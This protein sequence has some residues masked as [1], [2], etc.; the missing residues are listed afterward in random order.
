MVM[1]IV[2]GGKPKAARAAV[3]LLTGALVLA[4]VPA[5]GDVWILDRTASEIRFT[6]DHLGLSRQSGRFREIDG[7]LDFTPTDPE[8]GRIEATIHVARLSTGVPELDQLLKTTDFLDTARFPTAI[9]RS[10]GVTKTGEKTGDVNGELTM[11]GI[12]RPVTLQVTW[13][14]TGEYPLSAINPTYLGKWV[15][16]FSATTVIRR[17]EWGVKRGIPLLSDEIEIAIEAEFLRQE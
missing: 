14:F 6:Y 16:G 17:S 2:A 8:S 9:F 13:N 3:A 7:R 12:T 11:M 1:P 4:A 5:R 10:T 15:S